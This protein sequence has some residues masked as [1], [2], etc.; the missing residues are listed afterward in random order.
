M[1]GRRGLE[2]WGELMLAS[3]RGHEEDVAALLDS[4]LTRTKRTTSAAPRSFMPQPRGTTLSLRCCWPG[5]G[6]CADQTCCASNEQLAAC[7]E[8][9][10]RNRTP[11][12]ALLGAIRQEDLVLAC[13]LVVLICARVGPTTQGYRCALFDVHRRPHG[14]AL[15]SILWASK[16]LRPVAGCRRPC[17]PN[18]Q[19]GPLRP[20]FGCARGCGLSA[21]PGGQLDRLGRGEPGSRARFLCSPQ[22]RPGGC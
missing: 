9:R 4:R 14:V 5:E 1:R 15:G 21:A 10:G 22:G 12:A 6:V 20:G 2:G 17:A 11:F 19:R 13:E 16:M 18:R 7:P 3:F 8:P